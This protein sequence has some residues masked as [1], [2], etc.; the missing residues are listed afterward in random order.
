MSGWRRPCGAAER[1][2]VELMLTINVRVMRR[3]QQREESIE[4]ESEQ[5]QVPR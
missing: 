3:L 2:H 5:L 1:C 4:P